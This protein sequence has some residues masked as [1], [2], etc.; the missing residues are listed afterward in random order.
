[1]VRHTVC[2]RE[3]LDPDLSSTELSSLYSSSVYSSSIYSSSP[4]LS[5]PC[6]S[7]P[8]LSS[9]C[10]SSPAYLS[11]PAGLSRPSLCSQKQPSSAEPSPSSLCSLSSPDVC[12][13]DMLCSA[14]PSP[15]CG[16]LSPLPSPPRKRRRTGGRKPRPH[17]SLLG[18][19]H[20]F[21]AC[22]R[23][24][25]HACLLCRERETNL[26]ASTCCR[27]AWCTGC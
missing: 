10:L 24:T 2:P 27:G 17:S 8:C 16:G 7:S 26:I 9:P 19:C 18:R 25:Q 1:M 22:S 23:R 12:S 20:G 21:P 5:S 13:P 14:E 3:M 15:P 4:C 11:S 6:L